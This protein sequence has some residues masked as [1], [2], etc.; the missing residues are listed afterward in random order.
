MTIPLSDDL[1]F[2]MADVACVRAWEDEG[3]G[4]Y[5]KRLLTMCLK[6]EHNGWKQRTGMTQNQKI[7]AHLQKAGSITMREALIEYSI[8]CL[9]KRI[10]ELRE[11]GANII[12]KVKHHPIT[13]QKYV[14][15]ELVKA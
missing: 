8:Q 4:P 13:K 6:K 1:L 11:G 7:M 3:W 15:Y 5:H 12:S 2:H 9:T 14:R 10:Q